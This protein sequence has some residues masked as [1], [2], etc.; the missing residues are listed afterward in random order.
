MPTDRPI[1]ASLSL[2]GLA[3]D[4]RGA[5]DLAAGAGF[6]GVA[7]STQH[8]ELGPRELGESGRR[9]LKTILAG[10]RLA[11]ESLRAGGGGRRGGGGGGGRGLAD[12][13]TVDAAMDHARAAMVLARELGVKTVALDVGRIP[14]GDAGGA[15]GV[16]ALS[17][18]A[19][20]E[21]TLVL[22]LRELAQAADAS[23]ITLALGADSAIGLARIVKAVDFDGAKMD[24]D[25]AREIAAAEDPLRFAGDFGG[26]IGQFTAADAV[27][28]GASMRSV[29]LGEGQ[30]PL[31]ELYGIL[32]EHGFAGPLVV[33]VRDLPDKAQAVEH[34]AAVLRRI[35]GT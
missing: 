24:L 5:F 7:F 4:A 11:I 35:L 6:R 30:L 3:T 34:A 25:G 19:L 1:A 10:K 21:A 26:R 28:S 20:P 32:R 16:A 14:E 33:D 15:G 27:R 12:S 18:H 29:M 31:S 17:G 23:G 9:H 22:A 2:D 8:P 13:R